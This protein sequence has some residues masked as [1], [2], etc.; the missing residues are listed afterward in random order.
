[1]DCDP[2]RLEAFI[3]ASGLSFRQNSVSWI[4]A[5]PRC[6]KK[7]K[8]Y[9]RRSDGRFVCWSC[10]TETGFQ[11]K[12]EYALTEL[13]GLPMKEVRRVLYGQ[14]DVEG[15][16]EFRTLDV[17]DFFGSGDDLDVDAVE[18]PTMYWPYD[19]YFPIDDPRAARGRAYL[20]GRGVPLEIASQYGIRYSAKKRKVVFP[21]EIGGRLVGWQERTILPT[22]RWDEA[23]QDVVVTAKMLSSKGIPTSQT[24]MFLDRLVGKD[25][26]VVCEGPLDAIKLHRAGGNVCTMGKEVT[27]GQRATMRD[28]NR[29]S[30]SDLG[31]IF[32]SG[33][34]RIYLALDPDA[35]TET[36]R[37]ISDFSDLET[38]LISVPKP[39][40]DFGDMSV[41]AAYDAFLAAKRVT[42]SNWIGHFG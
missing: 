21:V 5:C 14:R 2:G 41:D 24:V 19:D 27:D 8:L 32:N 29:L 39:H 10:R 7:D 37:L 16:S 36:T 4:F 18:I 42:P 12:A 23:K 40:K 9:V 11:G 6:S 34:K 15:A 3:E 17:G 30:R 20:E 31:L 28:A 1:M 26:V 35:A 22:K 38:Y 33:I 25:Y 13:T